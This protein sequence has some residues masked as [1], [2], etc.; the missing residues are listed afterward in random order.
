MTEDFE[1]ALDQLVAGEID[2]I[3]VAPKDFLD[4]RRLWQERPERKEIIGVAQRNGTILY[5]FKETASN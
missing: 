1:K 2:Q 5:K 4:F 3:E